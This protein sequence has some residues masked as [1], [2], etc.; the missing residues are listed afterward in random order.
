MGV[1][2]ALFFIIFLIYISIGLL[3]KLTFIL[4]IRWICYIS[5][6]EFIGRTILSIKQNNLSVALENGLI[7]SFL[8]IFCWLFLSNTAVKRRQEKKFG[9]QLKYE[10]ERLEEKLKYE[11]QLLEHIENFFYS[12]QMAD[13][14]DIKKNLM[15][16]VFRNS[17]N[18]EILSALDK[19]EH[20]NFIIPVI[21]DANNRVW[22]SNFNIEFENPIESRT[23]RMR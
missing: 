7:A 12:N 8:S 6:I 21:K 1:I 15:S 11:A 20:N 13:L 2:L 18:F 22:K 5:I 14:S 23:I 19:L 9:L 4:I 17:S 3:K 10:A 16:T